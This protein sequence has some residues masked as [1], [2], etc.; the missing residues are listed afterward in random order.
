MRG[1]AGL[2]QQPRLSTGDCAVTG[3]I[4]TMQTRV[5]TYAVAKAATAAGLASRLGASDA[6]LQG[7]ALSNPEAAQ[8]R[9]NT[10]AIAVATRRAAASSGV[11]QWRWSSLGSDRHGA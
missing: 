9:A 7:Y 3:F 11:G 1:R 4:A 2:W 10:A 6:R 5:R 8:A